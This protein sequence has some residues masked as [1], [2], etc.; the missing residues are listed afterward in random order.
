MRRVFR[1]AAV[2]AQSAEAVDVVSDSE[3]A[4]DENKKA[5]DLAAAIEKIEADRVA[6][7]RALGVWDDQ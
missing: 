3:I 1:A 5:K 6:E 4:I 2:L 7:L